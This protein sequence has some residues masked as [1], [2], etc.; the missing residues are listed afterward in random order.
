MRKLTQKQINKRNTQF[1]YWAEAIRNEIKP[2]EDGDVRAITAVIA[3]FTS[4][5]YPSEIAD[6]MLWCDFNGFSDLYAEWV[7]WTN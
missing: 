3:S 6:F 7:I 1:R 4:L 5:M 2:D